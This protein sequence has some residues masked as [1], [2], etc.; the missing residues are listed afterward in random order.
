MK[1]KLLKKLSWVQ[2]VV[3]SFGLMGNGAAMAAAPGSVVINEIAW[4]GS[5]DSANDEW[6]ELYN[7]GAQAV[8]LAGWKLRDDGTDAFTF[9]AGASIAAGGYFLIEDNEN[10]VSTVTADAIYNMSLANSGDTLQLIDDSGATIDTVNA[11]GG[12]WYAGSQTNF[13]SME[14]ISAAGGDVATNFAASTGNGAQASAGGAIVGTPKLLNSVST[15]PVGA[16]KITAEF[17]GNATVGGNVKMLIKADNLNDLFAY[18]LDLAFDPAVL[19]YQSAVSKGFLS[20]NGAVATSFQSALK[21]GSAGHLLLAEAR[22]LDAKVGRTGSG[23]LV[24]VTFKVLT[25]P[26]ANSTQISFATD[27]FAASTTSDLVVVFQSANLTI[28]QANLLPVSGLTAVEAAGRYQ[29]KL[30]WTASSAS[31]DHYRV[32]RKDVHGNWV[33]LAGVTG[34][35]FIDQDNVVGGGKIIPKADYQ[36]RVIVVKGIAVS[37]PA[38]IVGRDNRGIKGDNNRSDLVDG[39]DLERLA[40]HFAE[41]DTV[42]GF[43]ALIDTTYD[44]RIDGSDLIDIGASFAQKY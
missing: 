42:A 23:E 8:S 33:T 14:R 7:P 28:G 34:T 35:E 9:P 2:M 37:E 1:S 11:S 39:R 16:T 38:L 44:G 24:E 10:V 22:T 6:I 5:V 19:E 32:E 40:R 29:I 13:A 4:A 31:P 18:G 17:V 43:D 3:L 36:Y 27:S 12:A 30:A 21:A 20:Q 41:L 25:Q 15:V 26:V